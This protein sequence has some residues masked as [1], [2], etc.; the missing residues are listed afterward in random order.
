MLTDNMKSTANTGTQQ[1]S[2]ERVMIVD[3]EALMSEILQIRLENEGYAASVCNDGREAL[4]RDLS[5]YSLVLVDLTGCE[6]NGIMF[7]NELKRNPKTA[8]VSVI[9]IS[10]KASEDDIVEALESGADDFIAKPISM[11]ILLA[12]VQSVMRR[13]RMVNAKRLA[14]ILRYDDLLV[15]MAAGTAYIDGMELSLSQLEFELLVLF[16]R[17][18]NHFLD[19]EVIRREV[20]GE[21]SVV[22]DRAVD[23]NVSRLRKKIFDYGANIINR[24]GFGYG[25]IVSKVNHI[26]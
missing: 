13:R 15:D 11:R 19:R 3:A 26:K 12:R 17:N 6:F 25:F 18:K 24:K 22:S 20:W 1:S 23:T 21:R 7:L 5:E 14:N 8:G 10:A 2:S 4:Q 9:L 16:M